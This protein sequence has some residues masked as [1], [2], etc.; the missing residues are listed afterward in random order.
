MNAYD[1][2]RLLRG[3]SVTRQF[4]K[5]CFSADTL[6]ENKG[7]RSAYVV[8]LDKQG[9]PGSH[10][11]AIFG[12]GNRCFYFDSF[13]L[14]PYVDTI[15]DWTRENYLKVFHNDIQHQRDETR[16]CGCFA[17]WFLFL[18]SSGTTF[19]DIIK[20]LKRIDNDDEYI[21]AFMSSVFNYVLPLDV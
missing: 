20:F 8:N 7:Y 3:N 6:P 18:M 10:W 5:G 21:V 19:Y 4:Y 1:I 2:D 13:G 11:V 15:K 9:E 17:V 12:E 16:T 14:P